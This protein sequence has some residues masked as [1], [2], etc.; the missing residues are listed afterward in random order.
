MDRKSDRDEMP[1]RLTTFREDEWPDDGSDYDL[2]EGRVVTDDEC[3]ADEEPAR[4]AVSRRIYAW[5]RYC[6]AR[7]AWLTARGA[8]VLDEFQA[9][10][11]RESVWRKE[12]DDERT[13]S[14]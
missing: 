4:A 8:P 14:E 10:A 6:R 3:V 5:R 9:E 11:R 7:R 12:L 13:K 1:D 2:T